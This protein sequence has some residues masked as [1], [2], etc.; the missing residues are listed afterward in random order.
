MRVTY[1]PRGKAREYAPLAVNLYSGCS[2]GCRYCYVPGCL[3]RSREAFAQVSVRRNVL[4][5]LR[6]DARE[7]CGD[8]RPVLLSFTSDPYQEAER[9]ERVTAEAIS[10]LADNGLK[11]R[12]LTKNP[13]LALE[14]DRDLLVRAKVEFGS[15]ILFV[16][17]AKRAA[18]EPHAPSI[19]SRIAGLRA[20]H[21]LGLETW[22]S[23][24][25]VIDPAEALGLF[26]RIHP[27]VSVWKVGKWNHDKR[28]DAID[29]PRFAWD[30]LTLLN[31]LNARYYIKDGLWQAAGPR[32]RGSFRKEVL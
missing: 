19:E 2:H 23:L 24:E 26:E 12:L 7:L 28:A 21:D 20:A 29:W 9:A 5:M 6:R 32:V 17:D 8:T 10:I 15:T 13:A 25:P 31:G 1:E 14:L 27:A 30:A 4:N 16:D 22:G 11:I 3:R 18:W